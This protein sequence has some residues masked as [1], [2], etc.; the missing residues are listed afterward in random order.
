MWW[1]L[2]PA[3][4]APAEAGSFWAAVGR[5]AR[6]PQKA[7]NREDVHPPR[8]SAAVAVTGTAQQEVVEALEMV[9]RR[10]GS[11]RAWVVAP[12]ARRAPHLFGDFDLD[13]R[14]QHVGTD[15]PL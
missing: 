1:C 11:V 5:L 14:V 7:A 15:W 13:G 12:G 2:G 9:R 3:P 6:Y 8:V 10:G 4:R